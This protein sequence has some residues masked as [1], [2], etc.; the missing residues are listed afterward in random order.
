MLCGYDKFKSEFLING[1][2]HGFRLYSV[3]EDAVL[4][5][6]NLLSAKQH[7]DIVDEKLRKEL[8][9]N[10]I[11]GPFDTPPLNQFT[12]SPLGIVPKKSPGEYRM[13]H[14]LSYPK[15]SSV[16]DGISD[17]YTSVHYASISDAIKCIKNC[18]V[19]SFLAK[20]DIKHAFRII[21]IHPDDHHLLGMK[22]KG[23]YYYDKCMPMG[24]ASSCRTFETFSTAIEW[25]AQ[26]ILGIS[27]I[28]H[29]LDDFLICESSFDLCKRSLENLLALC[30]YLGIPIAPEKTIGPMKVIS[31]VGIELDTENSVARLPMEKLNSAFRLVKNF[32]SRK[33]V[34]LQE[35]Q[36]LIGTLN[37]AC[38]VIVPGR[39]FLRR[40]IDLTIGIKHPKHYIR[41]SREAKADLN[42]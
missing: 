9:A 30:E 23:L 33:K 19:G 31:F 27:N 4:E 40:I 8:D 20:T 10:R 38:S 41:L 24:C 39:A 26:H 14:H 16:N 21:P 7:P 17:E 1:F 34:T 32:K 28:I 36:S 35:L 6:P 18:G 3:I 2:K 13:I 5:A 22:W 25:I 12:V 42:V 15:G 37:F 11:A 29:V